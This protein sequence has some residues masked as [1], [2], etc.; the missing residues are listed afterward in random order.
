MRWKL[1][2]SGTRVLG[3]ALRYWSC[4]VDSVD[5]VFEARLTKAMWRSG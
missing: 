2:Q 1:A 4:D 3:L 5:S